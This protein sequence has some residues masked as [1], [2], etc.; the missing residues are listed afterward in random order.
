[1]LVDLNS[2]KFSPWNRGPEYPTTFSFVRDS[3]IEEFGIVFLQ[4]RVLFRIWMWELS[5]IE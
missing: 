5:T 1:M 3:R 2:S 4:L